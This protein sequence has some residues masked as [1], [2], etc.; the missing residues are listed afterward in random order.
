MQDKED[1]VPELLS[2][3]HNDF[4]K[5][6]RDNSN[7][8]KLYQ[9]IENDEATYKE[10]YMAA[11]EIGESL[12]KCFRNHLSSSV[13]P[14]GKMYYNIAERILTSTLKIDYELI[15]DITDKVQKAL[16]EKASIGIK[17]LTPEFSQDRVTG[18]VNKISSTEVFDDVAW[19]LNEPVKNFSL[20]IVDDSIKKN[21]EFHH[22]AGLSPRIIRK[23]E[24][25]CCKWCKNLA[26]IYNYPE[27]VPADVYKRHENCRCT[28]EY[29][30]GNGKMQNVHSKKWKTQEEHDK[31]EQRKNL[32]KSILD[33]QDKAALNQYKSFE[34]YVINEALREGEEMSDQQQIMMERLDR[35]LE[36]L[37]R[38]EGVTYRS[39]LSDRIFDIKK[40]WEKYTPGNVIAE[41]AYTS[42][43]VSVFDDTFDIQMIIEGKNG[44]DLREYTDFENEILFMRD[45]LF[46]VLMREGNRIWLREI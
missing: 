21:V 13:L 22:K 15:T 31:I 30:P 18:I 26:G 43:S 5:A 46:E 29:D 24:S 28:I 6:C 9:R 37:P 12:A 4:L 20:S 11:E 25:K 42:T 40:F 36:K 7:L 38:Y 35:A 45:T 39:I 17:S 23:A 27:D 8:Q 10:A 14:E 33:Y 19:I 34:S 44:R 32:G 1:I 16:N 3:I 41:R 2:K